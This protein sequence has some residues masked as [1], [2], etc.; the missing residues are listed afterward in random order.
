MPYTIKRLLD[1]PI[2]VT[3][4]SRDFTYSRD[5]HLFTADLTTLLDEQP[6]VVSLI[7]NMGNPILSSADVFDVMKLAHSGTESV[8]FHS[9]LGGVCWITRAHMLL[10]AAREVSI[11]VYAD[12]DQALEA[13]RGRV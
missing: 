9:Q 11:P 5:I 3:A 8:Y 13:L 12:L 4:W 6:D 10:E 1:A 2:I 7:L